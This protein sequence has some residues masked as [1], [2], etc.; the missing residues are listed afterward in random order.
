MIV[1][2]LE[3]FDAEF[4]ECINAGTFK[5]VLDLEQ[6]PFID[7]GG[8]ETIYNTVSSLGK[9]GGDL[10][11]LGLN[12]IRKDIFLTTRMDKLVRVFTDR[13]AAVSSLL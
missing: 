5:I 2:E 6:V 7:S 3:T 11:I 13:D 10:R 9:R 4:E 12:D 8:L 1:E